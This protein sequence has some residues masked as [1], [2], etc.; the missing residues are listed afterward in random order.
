[1]EKKS[2]PNAVAILVLGICSILISCFGVGLICGIVGL[3]L[4]APPKKMYNQSPETYSGYGMLNAGYIL[5]IIGTVLG[6]LWAFYYVVVVLI[7]GISISSWLP[8][9]TA[10]SK[11]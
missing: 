9:M 2:L 5:S 4:S 6:S 1:M 8:F 7:F 11:M 10:L 3:A